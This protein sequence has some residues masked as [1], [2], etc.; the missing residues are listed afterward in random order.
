MN[1]RI[2]FAAI[3]MAVAVG[4]GA[5]GAHFLETRLSPDSL[6]G[7]QT[8]VR[9]HLLHALALLVIPLFSAHGLRY[10][11]PWMLMALGMLMFAVSIYGLSSRALFGLEG[12]L[13]FL[14]PVTPIGGSMLIA[15]W[16]WLAVV[17]WR[18][19]AADRV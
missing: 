19:G 11:G 7:F 17:A 16:V 12:G 8:G 3:N 2:A 4:L 5:L 6:S 9:Y 15:S 10:R 18:S 1:K 14:G 13:R